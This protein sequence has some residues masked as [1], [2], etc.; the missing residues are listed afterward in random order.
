MSDERPV[1]EGYGYCHCG[2]LHPTIALSRSA[3]T[4][5]KCEGALFDRVAELELSPRRGGYVVPINKRPHRRRRTNASD[6]R[7]A[8]AAARGAAM[9]RLKN[10]YPEV[11]ALLYAE[12]RSKRGLESFPIEGGQL[13]ERR[14]AAALAGRN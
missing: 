12:E 9:R 8:A 6:R 2:D 10:I 13:D 7:R 3:G 1:V 11:F 4:C 5:P 14:L